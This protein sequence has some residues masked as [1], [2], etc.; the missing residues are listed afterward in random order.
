ML[1]IG[2]LFIFFILTLNTACGDFTGNTE[3][4]KSNSPVNNSSNNALPRSK[5]LSSN[6]AKGKALT[7]NNLASD[8]VEQV[9][10]PAV[11][12]LE[13]NVL[14]LNKELKNNCTL[15]P[16][17]N[18]EAEKERAIV[19]RYLWKKVMSSYHHLELFQIGP[20]M[21]NNFELMYNLYNYSYEFNYKYPSRI[22][23]RI[24][25]DVLTN[26]KTP[27]A[28]DALKQ[29]SS[30]LDAMEY[31]LFN[32]DL[33]HSC[34]P[35]RSQLKEWESYSNAQ[36]AA[37]RCDYITLISEKLVSDITNLAQRWEIFRQN[38]TQVPEQKLINDLVFAIFFIEKHTKDQALGIPT[39]LSKSI[40]KCFG[41]FC[42]DT[43]EHSPSLF[44]K[45]HLLTQ[46]KAL[47]SF[48]DGQ[49]SENENYKGYGFYDY[50]NKIE[51][52]SDLINKLKAS[53]KNLK[54][55]LTQL[56][57]GFDLKASL[58][59]VDDYSKCQNSTSR[60]RTVEICAIYQDLR[61][62]TQLLKQEFVVALSVRLPVDSEGD[63]D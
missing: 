44:L 22:A 25:Y 18:S 8:L 63:A 33:Q 57:A 4:D 49:N 7:V 56:P 28:I 19:L 43:I 40:P 37:A 50:L 2:N 10:T 39:G 60:N 15:Q 45:E 42:L 20:L 26:S 47:S 35:G 11:N 16:L 54:Q 52:H 53:I 9:I 30:G 14:L 59:K 34:E 5:V 31:L 12:N 24:D 6:K 23:C 38:I 51:N 55:N 21:D 29:N 61:E 46:V 48:F 41:Q 62:I 17:T 36:R 3:S 58:K 32:N 13:D 1:K 27:I